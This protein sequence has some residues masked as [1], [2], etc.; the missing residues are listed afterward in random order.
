MQSLTPTLTWNGSDRR[1][2]QAPCRPFL[3]AQSLI[4]I[5][6]LSVAAL[7]VDAASVIP[8]ASFTF[9]LLAGWS[10]Y[11][12]YKLHGTL[13]DPY[14]LFLMSS[15][16]FNGAQILL[17]VVHLN[18]KGILG[19]IFSPDTTLRTA[20][21]VALAITTMHLGALWAGSPKKRPTN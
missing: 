14:P 18:T 17:E 20:Y 6:L 12:W 11:S 9:V 4:L 8:L 21:L 13:F 1:F 3:V 15:W 19:G 5:C 16:L 2:L 10:L 7:N